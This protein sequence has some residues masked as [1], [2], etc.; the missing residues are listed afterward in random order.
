LFGDN[1]DVGELP[2]TVDVTA[3]LQEE[4]DQDRGRPSALVTT[5]ERAAWVIQSGGIALDPRLHIFTVKGSLEPRVV[6]LYPRATCSCPAKSACYHIAAAKLSIGMSE[7]TSRRTL[8]LTQLRKNKRKRP[9]KTSGRKRPRF[10]D[11]DVIPAGDADADIAG[12]LA[13][14][15]SRTHHQQAP[16]TPPAQ[17]ATADVQPDNDLLPSPLATT[18]TQLLRREMVPFCK[19]SAIDKE[20]SK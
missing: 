18:M 14:R 10:N 9:D 16:H 6:Q 4:G 1:A 11:V 5:N 12:D 15:V 13:V 7:E 3:Q 19:K 17:P 20:R 8:S 2:A